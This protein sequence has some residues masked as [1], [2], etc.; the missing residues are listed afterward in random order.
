MQGFLTCEGWWF[1]SGWTRPE[2]LT[3]I[4]SSDVELFAQNSGMTGP[5]CAAP[6]GG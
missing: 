1:D 5:R 3:Q 6:A 2:T 4:T